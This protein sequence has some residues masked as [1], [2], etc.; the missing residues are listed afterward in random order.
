MR[1]EANLALRTR[2]QRNRPKNLLPSPLFFMRSYLT[3]PNFPAS[4][5]YAHVILRGIIFAAASSYYQQ[6]AADGRSAMLERTTGLPQS[7]DPID[8]IRHFTSFE[9]IVNSLRK[10]SLHRSIRD[11]SY[12]SNPADFIVMH[13]LASRGYMLLSFPLQREAYGTRRRAEHQETRDEFLKRG[14]LIGSQGLYEFRLAERVRTLPP[15]SE[16]INEID[17]LPIAIPNADV[18]F[19]R[20][21][22]FT[23]S[24]GTVLRLTGPSG[25]GKTSV[26]LGFA[27][28][29]AP[30]GINTIYLSCEENVDDLERRIQTLVP[31]FIRRTESYRRHRSIRRWFQARHLREGP[32]IDLREINL[33]VDELVQAYGDEKSVT[34]SNRPPGLT[35]LVIVL[36]GLHELLLTDRRDASRMGETRRLRNVVENSRR[37][38]ALIVVMS[39]DFNDPAVSDLDYVADLVADIAF[40][41]TDDVAQPLIR[42]FVLRKTRRQFARMGAHLLNLSPRI[43]VSLTPQIAAQRDVHRDFAWVE[44][45]TDAWFDVFRGSSSRSRVI[46]SHAPRLYEFSQV[47]VTGRGSTGKSAFALR[48]IAGAIIRSGV[49]ELGSF[50][51]DLFGSKPNLEHAAN[52]R[53]TLTE[54][55]KQKRQRRV[56]VLSFLYQQSYYDVIHQRLACLPKTQF[57]APPPDLRVDVETFYPGHLR[58]EDFLRKVIGLLEVSRLEGFPYEAVIID[59]LHNVFMQFPRLQETTILWPIT[60][61]MLRKYKVTVVTTHTHMEMPGTGGYMAF[62]LDV[63]RERAAPILQAL[64][65]AADFFFD[66]SP[67]DDNRNEFVIHTV[68][69]SD[70]EF[71]PDLLWDRN[72]MI[73]KPLPLDRRKANA[74]QSGHS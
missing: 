65:N 74:S 40:E 10:I 73:I 52:A 48:L 16:I 19:A 29:L 61:E 28:A 26:G 69:A 12:P 58:P 15:A 34:I 43:G 21:L 9:L 1:E 55:W 37:T 63:A 22:R 72:T 14:T 56:L 27:T 4:E 2:A 49:Q 60:Y 45:R 25:G 7:D 30:L 62:D 57:A 54:L 70:Q 6:L 18:I 17:G 64:I 41:K 44:R 24:E 53:A 33:L 23:G 50:D 67:E 20:G 11:V 68:N 13:I 3:D 42:K 39:A 66:L 32:E 51:N 59:G 71:P 5:A 36:D 47:L 38:G 35:P 8:V 46:N 31:D